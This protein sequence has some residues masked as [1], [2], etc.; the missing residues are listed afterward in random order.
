VGK[1]RN[2]SALDNL[3]GWIAMSWDRDWK[4]AERYFRR[5]RD[6]NPDE[7]EAHL[8]YAK[9]LNG[10]EGRYLEALGQ[11]ERVKEL[12]ELNYLDKKSDIHYSAGN[13]E[14][15]L[16]LLEEVL[17]QKPDDGSSLKRK[18]YCLDHLSRSEEA[19]LSAK[20]MINTGQDNPNYGRAHLTIVL[21]TAGHADQVRAE[22]ET[23][24]KNHE[25]KFGPGRFEID[26]WLLIAIV[27]FRLGN[28][29]LAFE[30]MNAAVSRK[31]EFGFQFLELRNAFQIK[32]F[33]DDPRYWAVI[34]R[35]N[36][37]AL[38]IYHPYYDKEQAMRFGKRSG[39]QSMVVD[40]PVRSLAILPFDNL[41]QD[42]KIAWLSDTMA[43][44][45]HQKLGRMDE[46]VVRR[47]SIPLKQFTAE[48]KSKSDAATQLKVDVLVS[49]NFVQ[50][51]GV[52]QMNVS[53]IHGRDGRDDPLG[54]FN[55]TSSNL[56]QI[57]NDV[58]MAI[59]KQVR[60]SLTEEEKA[61][62][63]ESEGIDPEAYRM[64][65]EG[66][67]A[68]DR[69]TAEGWA[70]TERLMRA[71]LQKD[72]GYDDAASTL[73][74]IP[75][76]QNLF[77]GTET[78]P[79]EAC[80]ESRTIMEQYKGDLRRPRR[81]NGTKSWLA[82]Y[83]ER[84]WKKAEKLCRTFCDDFPEL[85]IGYSSYSSY[86][87]FVEGR[88]LEALQQINLA[89]AIEPDR[90]GLLG[91]KANAY[92]SASDYEA[93]LEILDEILQRHPD[94]WGT[95]H[96]KATCL[97]VLGRSAEALTLANK[98]VKHSNNNPVSLITLGVVLARS[99]Q[100]AEAREVL[101]ELE[102]LA[103]RVYVDEARMALIESSLGSADRAFELLDIA[104]NKKGRWGILT[105]RQ[106]L[107]IELMGEDPRYW[108]V[109]DRLNFPALPVY[110]PYYEKEQVM[111][112]GKTF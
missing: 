10:V 6:S 45:I 57:Q 91:G 52:L 61:R 4:A 92:Y 104:V 86:L 94:H 34:D 85:A 36:F 105:L 82:M 22:L 5:Y 1:L 32:L 53:L 77:G 112:F 108:A 70:E 15:A 42:E 90:L 21:A 80:A 78:T 18:V 55:N 41:N 19:I 67:Q 40:E 12:D 44:A 60:T 84:N 101:S 3:K 31:D 72:P 7:I 93:C 48:G 37:P 63:A 73:A 38:P 99:G 79:E 2:D 71:A 29:D 100:E 88:Y 47:G 58:A 81:L 25:V 98:A 8:S 102:E 109:V 69:Q 14:T 24:K 49:G 59:A 50:Y 9:Y 87:R 11:I 62:I 30:A 28:V 16:E 54:Q 56:F 106:P 75:W 95:I 33:G 83:E 97:L 27:E 26:R 65:Q 68:F 96:I 20:E 107:W 103:K 39:K 17:R 43:D 23:Y 89:L 111:R 110:H 51:E 76:V 35:L 74:S 13:Y 64:F 66:I 46:I